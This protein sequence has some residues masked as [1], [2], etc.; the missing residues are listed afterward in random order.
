MATIV[1]DGGEHI[2][3]ESSE[4]DSVFD[5]LLKAQKDGWSPTQTIGRVSVGERYIE[6]LN[7]EALKA[8]TAE[9]GVIG[10]WLVQEE[11]SRSVS[12]IISDS[13]EYLQRLES[14][15]QELSEKI[16]VQGNPGDHQ[17][18]SDGVSGLRTI[19]ELFGTFLQQDN[20][21]AELREEFTGFLEELN[22]KSREL[23]EAQE[24]GDMTMIADI[25]EYEFVEAI[26]QLRTFL[27]KMSEFAED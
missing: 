7:E 15:F 22:E 14:G 19:L 23:N 8:V 3:V 6:P 17:S 25:L 10:V 20:L 13:G 21:P 12:Q 27:E 16:R 5:I 2:E 24:S 11:P 26:Q 9:G 1:I 18:L 4:S